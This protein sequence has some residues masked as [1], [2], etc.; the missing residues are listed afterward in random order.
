M[1]LL[2]MI[3]RCEREGFE[4]DCVVVLV[5]AVSK[6]NI[7][8]ATHTEIHYRTHFPDWPA[9]AWP[10]KMLREVTGWEETVKR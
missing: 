2:M 1:S 6:L 9:S 10:L 7:V 8:S 3:D 4:R 5:P